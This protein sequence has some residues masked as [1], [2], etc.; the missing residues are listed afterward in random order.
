[1]YILEADNVH[2]LR[3]KVEY[4]LFPFGYQRLRNIEENTIKIITATMPVYVLSRLLCCIVLKSYCI[5]ENTQRPSVDLFI[6]NID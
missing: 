6:M 4:T 2:I 3:L 5:L 1:M